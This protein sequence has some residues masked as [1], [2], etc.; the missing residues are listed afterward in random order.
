MTEHSEQRMVIDWAERKQIEYPEL[1]WLH[2]SL[3]GIFIPAPPAIR[4]RIINHMKAE[5]MKKGI[6]DLFLPVARRDYHG[7]YI[8]LKRS[9]G[10]RVREEQ[11]EFLEFAASQGYYSQV[12]YGYD[13]AVE[14]LEWYLNPERETA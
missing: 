11:N 9:D 5:G 2:S 12:C 4:A 10:G 1:K 13:E 14:T 6:P 8:E 7:L 3:N